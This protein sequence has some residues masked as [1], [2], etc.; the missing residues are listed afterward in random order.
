MGHFGAS[1][2]EI[3]ILFEQRAGHRL[4]SVKVTRPHARAHRPISISSFPVSEGIEIRQRCRFASSLIRALGELSGGIGRFL[5]CQ[6]V[7]YVIWC[8]SSAQTV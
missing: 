4:L 8:E 7:G 3:L 5:H 1:Y 6:V 2:L